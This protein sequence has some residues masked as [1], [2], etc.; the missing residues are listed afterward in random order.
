M[1]RL[2]RIYDMLS[3]KNRLRILKLLEYKP[4]CVCELT[5]VLGIRQPSVSRHLRKLKETGL[6]DSRQ[7]GL[8]SEYYIDNSG[9]EYS[10]ILMNI[11]RGWINNDPVV[12]EDI[13]KA[14]QSCREVL[15][16]NQKNTNPV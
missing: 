5:Y 13:K 15:C 3:D 7:E 2:S 12:V 9:D 4:M 8:W 6:I 11:L 14:T 16:T 1:E 10:R